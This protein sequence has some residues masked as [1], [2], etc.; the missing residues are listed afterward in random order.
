MVELLKDGSGGRGGCRA[1]RDTTGGA[2]PRSESDLEE[3][4]PAA[5]W[6]G[7]SVGAGMGQE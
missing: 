1:I 2:G 7:V 3:A 5:E 4:G 6:S